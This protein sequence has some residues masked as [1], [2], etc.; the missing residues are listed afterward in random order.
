M[1]KPK[2]SDS[3][4]TKF[5]LEVGS[6]TPQ[7]DPPPPAQTNSAVNTTPITKAMESL[8]PP[9]VEKEW[10]MNEVSVDCT[11]GHIVSSVSILILCIL[12]NNI[13]TLHVFLC[14][15]SDTWVKCFL[16]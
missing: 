11:C 6:P 9:V 1:S 3:K 8:T 12:C 7:D 2:K 16:S 4:T 10:Y 5:A 13:S 15:V 14:S